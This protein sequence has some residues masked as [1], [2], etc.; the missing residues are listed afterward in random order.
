M[1]DNVTTPAYVFS[2]SEGLA[3]TFSSAGTAGTNVDANASGGAYIFLS[4]TG[5]GDWIQFTL[6]SA[7]AGAILG[8]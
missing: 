4:A 3:F 1:L 5:A 2:E 8:K 6:P 7:N